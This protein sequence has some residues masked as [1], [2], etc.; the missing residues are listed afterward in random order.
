MN[1]TLAIVALAGAV[2]A[3]GCVTT[4]SIARP[5][6]VSLPIVIGGAAADL[7][8]TSFATYQVRDSSSGGALATG[9]A[10]M[11]LDLAVGC[12]LGGCKALRP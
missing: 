11:A 2:A 4:A 3:S 12:L 5:Q 6:R 8:V 7:I 1:R 10:V 9:V